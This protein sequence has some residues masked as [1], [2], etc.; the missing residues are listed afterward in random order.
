MTRAY[1]GGQVSAERREAYLSKIRARLEGSATANPVAPSLEGL[2]ADFLD[3][4]SKFRKQTELKRID[5]SGFAPNEDGRPIHDWFKGWGPSIV[6]GLRSFFWDGNFDREGRQNETAAELGK[7]ID[8]AIRSAGGNTTVIDGK[9]EAHE[10]LQRIDEAVVA[11]REAVSYVPFAVGASN[12]TLGAGAGKLANASNASGAIKK[13]HVL[14]GKVSELI[15]KHPDLQE[16]FPTLDMQKV[17]TFSML[18]SPI[19]PGAGDAV[20]KAKDM[21]PKI[22]EFRKSLDSWDVMAAYEDIWK[23]RAAACQALGLEAEAKVC[24]EVATQY[25]SAYFEALAVSW[26]Q[27]QKKADAEELASRMPRP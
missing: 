16:H 14:H 25:D 3:A 7:Y 17:G 19:T 5:T 9:L 1:D 22:D 4:V 15:A 13:A 27:P 6:A 12:L 20:T 10:A 18:G 2:M 26:A 23:N 21:L 8:G 24:A 11:L